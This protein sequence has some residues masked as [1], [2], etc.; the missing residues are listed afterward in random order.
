MFKNTNI[1]VSY[2]ISTYIN[3]IVYKSFYIYNNNIL[4]IKYNK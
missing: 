3:N 1:L 2:K 4:I